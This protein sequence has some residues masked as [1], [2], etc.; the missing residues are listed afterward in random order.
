MGENSSRKEIA[1]ESK[2]T[3]KVIVPS[4]AKKIRIDGNGYS[5]RTY[6][7]QLNDN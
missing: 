1:R 5:F 2:T 7:I 4:G 3:T 6:E